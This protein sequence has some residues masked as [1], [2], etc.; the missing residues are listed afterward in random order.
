MEIRTRQFPIIFAVAGKATIDVDAGT[1]MLEDDPVV[2]EDKGKVS[3]HKIILFRGQQRVEVHGK[4]G[5]TRAKVTLPP[6]RDLGALG[7]KLD[8]K[9]D[10]A[11]KQDPPK[12]TPPRKP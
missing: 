10:D 5:E 2:F 8:E 3:G 9:K 7:K 6:I 1:I 4:P 12:V 11:R